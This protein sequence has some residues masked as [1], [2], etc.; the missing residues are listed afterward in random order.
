MARHAGA[1]ALGRLGA[2]LPVPV[3]LAGVADMMLIA[4]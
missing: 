3:F 1:R 4:A 2:A